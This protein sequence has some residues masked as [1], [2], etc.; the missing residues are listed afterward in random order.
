MARSETAFIMM[1]KWFFCIFPDCYSFMTCC[2]VV[3][4]TTI[5]HQCYICWA[6]APPILRSV[7]WLYWAQWVWELVRWWA[8]PCIAAASWCSYNLHRCSILEYW[9][10]CPP[11]DTLG[12]CAEPWPSLETTCNAPRC[13]QHTV[14]CITTLNQSGLVGV[15][16]N[17]AVRIRSPC[18]FRH[19]SH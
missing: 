9:H 18:G 15:D 11:V 3:I 8:V 14:T 16:H 10:H 19:G 17:G 1:A 13:G 4:C 5:F 7:C 12:G 2:T 6:L